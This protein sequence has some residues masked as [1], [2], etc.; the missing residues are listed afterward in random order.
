M[1][2]QPSGLNQAECCQHVQGGD[3]APLLSTTGTHLESWIQWWTEYM[4]AMDIVERVQQGIDD[5][6]RTGAC[7]IRA[8]AERARTV[9]PGEEQAQTEGAFKY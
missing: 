8:G 7:L 5:D 3:P 9:Q 1:V 2:P 4:R 6:E